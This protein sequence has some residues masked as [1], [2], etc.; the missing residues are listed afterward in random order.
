[1]QCG[2]KNGALDS[3]FEAAILQQLREDVADPEPLPD[4]AEQQRPADALGLSRHRPFGVRI[5]RVDEE[6]LIGELGAGSKQ[7]G[8]GAGSR[9]LVGAAEIGDDGLAHGGTFALVLDDLHVAA[10][11]GFFDAEEHCALVRE[12]HRI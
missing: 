6:H 3:E 12:H 4:F 7:R 2:N 10:F 8:Q 5:K 11:A 9:K 1:M